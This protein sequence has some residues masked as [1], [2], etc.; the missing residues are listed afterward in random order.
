MVRTVL[1]AAAILLAGGLAGCDGCK[2]DGAAGPDASE[3]DAMGCGG[4]TP[5]AADQACRYDTCVPTPVPCGPMNACAGDTYC[6]TTTNECLPWGVGPGGDHDDACIRDVVPGVF[7][8]GV[9]CEW[10]GP[11]AGDP[12]PDHKNVLGSPMVATFGGGG[13]GGEFGSPSIVFISYNFTDG[14]AESCQGTDARYF[15]VLRVIDGRTCEQTATFPDPLIASQSVAIGDLGGDDTS[16]EIV[17]ARQDGGLIAFTHR[18]NGAWDVLWRSADHYGD[19]FCNWTGLSIHDLD[20]DGKPEILFEGAVYSSDGVLENTPP[21]PTT[22]DPLANGYIPVVGDVD[23]DGQPE[24]V[25]GSRIYGWDTATTEWVPKGPPL[26]QAGRVAIADLGTYGADPAADDRSTLDGIPEIVSVNGG[27]V[28]AYALSGR[29]V[30]SGNIQGPVPGN[31]GPPT[32]ADFDGDGRAEIASAGGTAYTVF[33]PDCVA[34]AP[35][36]LCA[37]GRADGILWFQPSQDRSSNVTGSSVFDFEGD[38]RAEAVYADECFTRVYDGTTG[39]VEY[40]RFRRSCT[41]YENP[42]IADVDADFNAEIVVN[43]NTNCSNI[44]CPELDPI[45][46]GIRCLDDSD[47]TGATRCGREQPGD[48]LGRCRCTADADCGG[49]GFVCRDPIAGPSPAGQVCRASNPG[50]GSAFGVRVLADRVDRW[51]NTRPIWNQHAYSVT[52]VNDDGTIPRTS[53]WL[54]NWTQAGLNNF[55]QNSPG[56][57]LGAGASPDLTVRDATVS[58]IPGGA[59]VAIDVCNRGTEPVARGLKVS[60]YGG[61]PPSVLGCTAMTTFNLVVGQCEQVSCDWPAA[62][63]VGTVIVDDDGTGGGGMAGAGQNL[64]CHEDNNRLVLHDLNCPLGP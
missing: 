5:C 29:L 52:N 2:R 59:H 3:V 32:I 47:C 21:A 53:Q 31:G 48:A 17:A 34:G 25:T 58:C 49:D 22:L 40:S 7:F 1:A 41:W 33:D 20:D 56:T 11:P 12:F 51:V 62:G 18:G 35:A 42:I 61:D 37:S 55:R 19:N 27:V 38:G 36:N 50:V 45:F 13:G 64:E 23:G 43:S 39:S 14:G 28:R 6:D 8:P 57:G 24:L 44:V 4:D 30:F 60:V 10:L 46:D 63:S 26:G 9:Q 16:P 15:G 54:R